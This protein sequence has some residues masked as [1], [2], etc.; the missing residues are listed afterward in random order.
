VNDVGR[1]I[2]EVRERY[3]PG[4]G[5]LTFLLPTP[6]RGF[7]PGEDTPQEVGTVEWVNDKLFRYKVTSTKRGARFVGVVYE[8]LRHTG[9]V[10]PKQVANVVGVWKRVG[11][12]PDPAD[13]FRTSPPGE[14]VFNANRTF[15]YVADINAQQTYEYPVKGVETPLFSYRDGILSLIFSSR[16]GWDRVI[17]RGRVDWVSEDHFKFRLLDGKRTRFSGRGEVHEFR[18]DKAK[19]AA[20]KARP[21]AA[22][23]KER[24]GEGKKG[25][26]VGVWEGIDVKTHLPAEVLEFRRDG[27]CLGSLKTGQYKFA[28]PTLTFNFNYSRDRP[29]KAE[30]TQ[31]IESGRVQWVNGQYFKYVVEKSRDRPRTEGRE[32][33]FYRQSGPDGGQG[34]A[35]IVGTWKCDVQPLPLRIRLNKDGT[36]RSLDRGVNPPAGQYYRYHDRILTFLDVGKDRKEVQHELGRVDWVDKDHFK[37]KVLRPAQGA[38][39]EGNVYDFRRDGKAP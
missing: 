2:D 25:D 26:F 14:F 27:S 15:S 35:N 31:F 17:E 37:L 28:D 16:H 5:T 29:T 20:L 23:G 13:R 30:Y 33:A 7:R 19:S 39:R 34:A 32:Y 8:Y 6:K 38:L 10:S 1:G 18:R 9:P 24:L 21:L 22:A 36:Y 11:P 3:R 12:K 4:G